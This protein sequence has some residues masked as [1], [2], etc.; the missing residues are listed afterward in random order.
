ML[1]D[2]TLAKVSGVLEVNISDH[3]LVFVDINLKSPK[4]AP[5]YVVTRSFGNYKA[6]QLQPTSPY[7]VGYC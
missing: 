5:T 7:P 6:D 3:F 2:P 1:S 4:Q